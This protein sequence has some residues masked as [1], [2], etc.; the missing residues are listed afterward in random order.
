MFFIAVS[1]CV[2]LLIGYSFLADERLGLLAFIMPDG[3]LLCLLFPGL[4]P[5]WGSNFLA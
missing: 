1:R 2:P 5:K 4:S 3:V